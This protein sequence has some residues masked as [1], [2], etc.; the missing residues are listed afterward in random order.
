MEYSEKIRSVLKKQNVEVGDSVSVAKNDAVYEGIVMPNTDDPDTLV[1]KL[2]NGYNIGL[3]I[4]GMKIK[5]LDRRHAIA[6]KP[7]E[8]LKFDKSKP[9]VSLVTT[10]GTITSKIDYDTG[11]VKALMTSEEFMKKTPEMAE[12]ANIEIVQPFTKMSEG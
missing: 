2:E 9:L 6:A 11:A 1:L 12:I 10:G 7:R 8:G 4:S 3:D 5:K